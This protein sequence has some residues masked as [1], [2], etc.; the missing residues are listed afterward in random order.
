MDKGKAFCSWCPS[1][2]E[3]DKKNTFSTPIPDE[4][5]NLLPGLAGKSLIQFVCPTCKEGMTRIYVRKEV[6]C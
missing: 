6:Y 1:E 5:I 4:I 2:V 3:I